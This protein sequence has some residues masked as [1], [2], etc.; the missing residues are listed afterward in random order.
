MSEHKICQMINAEKCADTDNQFDCLYAFYPLDDFWRYQTDSVSVIPYCIRSLSL[1]PPITICQNNGQKYTF[2]QWKFDNI[3]CG[4]LYEWNVP[5]DIT[6]EYGKYLNYNST[7]PLSYCNY[8]TCY[9]G[10]KC[11]GQRLYLDWRQICNSIVDC[12]NGEDELDCLQ[13]EINE[14]DNKT[15]YHC[16]SGMCIDK[17]FASDLIHDCQDDSDED[18]TIRF[19]GFVC[20]YI[21]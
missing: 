4:N 16:K 13:L 3:T 8:L 17:T 14:C 11:V 5:I 21:N 18:V 20:C 15:E 10:L 19:V 1:S 12:D 9:M 2:E 7:L 6:D